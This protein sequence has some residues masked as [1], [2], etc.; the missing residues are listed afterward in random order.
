M[1]ETQAQVAGDYPF[2]SCQTEKLVPWRIK[3]PSMDKGI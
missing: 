1:C 2:D 3:E